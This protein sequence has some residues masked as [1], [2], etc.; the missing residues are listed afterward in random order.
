MEQRDAEFTAY[1]AGHRQKLLRTAYLLCGSWAQ[2]EDVTQ[3]ALTKLYTAW[4]R[5]RA[6]QSPTAY[7]R[8]IIVRTAADERRRPWRREVAESQPGTDGSGGSSE[9]SVEDRLTLARALPRLPARQ[10]QVVVLRYYWDL[11]VA[12]TAAQLGISQGSVKSHGARA[13]VLLRSVLLTNTFEGA[14]LDD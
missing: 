13:L 8:R 1:V 14:S 10:R 11:S 5:V 6:D 3:I 12:E 4:P 7:V 2:A 9:P